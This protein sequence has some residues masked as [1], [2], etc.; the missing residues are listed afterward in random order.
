MRLSLTAAVVLILLLAGCAGPREA[1][2]ERVAPAPPAAAPERPAAPA[3][4]GP[5]M[6]DPG[7]EASFR[8]RRL[9]E[10]ARSP[11]AMPATER[12]YYLDVLYAR[13][14]QV[15]GSEVMR[16]EDGTLRVRLP[17]SVSFEVGSAQL[18]APA[19]QALSSLIAPL[20]DFTSL[21]VSVHGHTDNTGPAEVNRRLSAQRAQAVARRLQAAG[22]PARHLLAV[23]HGAEQPIADN[24]SPEGRE[25]NR[26]VELLLEPIIA[27]TQRPT[28]PSP[29]G[30]A[31]QR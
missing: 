11:Q 17:P 12:G 15:P 27:S 19:E 2:R 4:S 21:L 29:P 18:S 6:L 14:R 16:G 26:R 5:T 10:L 9:D 24:E 31:G 7:N 30:S 3:A 8:A 23:G 28:V 20:A 13:L 22:V 25:R 1:T